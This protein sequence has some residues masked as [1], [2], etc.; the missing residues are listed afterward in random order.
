[1]AKDKQYTG[2]D[3]KSLTDREH[4]RLRTEVYLG[5]MSPTQYSI[6]LLSSEKLLIK[7]VEF[8]PAVYKAI[9]EIIDN[10]LDEFS[11]LTTRNKTL[12]ITAD[13]TKGL[14]VI[15][16]NGRGVPIDKHE[17]GKYTPEVVFG[18]L[19]SG[20]NFHDEKEMGVIG[21]NGVGSSCTNYCS[22]LFE[23]K[24]N[25]DGK[26]YTQKFTDGANTATKPKIVAGGKATGTQ[27]TFQLDPAVFSDVSLPNDLIRNRAMEI[28]MLNSDI[29]VEYNDEKFKYKNGLADY[30]TRLANGKLHYTFPVSDTDVEGEI[31]VIFDGHDGLDEQMFTW[32]NNSLLFDGGKCNTQFFN[33]LNDKV[34]AHLTPAAKKLKA[35]VTRNDVRQGLLVFANLKV[36]NPK[37]D[38]Q[39]K[40]RLTGPDMRK[41]IAKVMDDHWGRFSRKVKPW[42][43]E[44]LTRADE[45]HHRQADKNA[46][47]DHEKNLKRPKPEG[48]LDATSKN[49][50]E[51][52]LLITEGK[53]ANGQIS[54]SR[55]PKTTAA[56]A[57]TGKVNNVWNSTVAQVLQMGKLKDLLT[58]IGLVPGKRLVR[59]QLNYG[60][61]VI[62]TDADYDGDDIF[63]ILINLLYKFWPEMFDRNYPP[64][65]YRMVAPNVCLVKGDKRIHFPRRSEYEKVKDKYKGYEVKYYKGLGSMNKTDWDMCL[66]GETD[67]FIPI[68]DDG[69]MKDVLCLLFSD[70]VEA[71]KEWLQA[72]PQ[73]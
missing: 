10:S 69:R 39:A 71:R 67:T 52:Q 22:S 45:R 6:P 23:V 24:I 36:K 51:C 54:M 16:D 58:A 43:D 28:A 73:S 33:A 37:Y 70:D 29:T 59:S 55:D 14:Y 64:M 50:M 26:V 53:S 44:V 57:L 62:A 40:T 2:K 60:K 12:K 61:I 34:I 38:S 72:T 66:S 13:T 21:M 65:V 17:T 47:I 35:E 27:L 15:A 20:R 7:D 19:R 32:V 49:R 48:L 18:S 4:V 42:L 3:I 8:I 41:D 30:V 31:H 11:H 9:G 5:S 68:V 46:V 63:T 25:K 56:F 1:M